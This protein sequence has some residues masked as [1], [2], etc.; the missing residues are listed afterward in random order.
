MKVWALICAG[1]DEGRPEVRLYAYETHARS[2]YAGEV[3]A[4]LRDLDNE[5][6]DHLHLRRDTKVTPKN[7]EALIKAYEA[8]GRDLGWCDGNGVPNGWHLKELEVVLHV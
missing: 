7:C 1:G 8:R 3:L 4:K 5:E 2:A 6:F